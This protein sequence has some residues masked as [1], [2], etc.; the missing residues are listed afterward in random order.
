M[1]ILPKIFR[2]L[3]STVVVCSLHVV[4]AADFFPDVDAVDFT[5]AAA[6]A[7][8]FLSTVADAASSSSSAAP[9]SSNEALTVE[10]EQDLARLLQNR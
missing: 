7:A 5:S 3:F 4:D 10:L 2:I 8:N 9:S 6:S 1:S